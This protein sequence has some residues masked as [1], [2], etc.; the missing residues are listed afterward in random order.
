MIPLVISPLPLHPTHLSTA[1]IDQEKAV[2]PWIETIIVLG[3]WQSHT[4]PLLVLTAKE[5]TWHA[6]V[7]L[8]W[9]VQS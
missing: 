4:S 1:W 2:L 3:N 9:S 8:L 7:S 6:M 5:P